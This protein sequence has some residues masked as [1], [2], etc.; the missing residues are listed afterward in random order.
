MLVVV[1]Q[2]SIDIADKLIPNVLTMITQLVATG[3]LFMVFKKYLYKP[4]LA[5][6]DKRNEAEQNRL[7]EAQSALEKAQSIEKD[8]QEQFKQ[9]STRI[10]EMVETAKDEAER[11]Y[12]AKLAEGEL[13][14]ANRKKRAE[15]DLALQINAARSELRE[16]VIAVAMMAS[17]KLLKEK[18]DQLSDQERIESFIG[19]IAP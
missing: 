2:L 3:I 9:A 11:V 6:I 17:E 13:E 14:I 4:V 8:R 18:Y 5:Y 7:A 15:A 16:E 12:Q 1:G 19:D 10:S